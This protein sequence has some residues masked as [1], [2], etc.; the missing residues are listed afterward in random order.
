MVQQPLRLVESRSLDAHAVVAP[1]GLQLTLFTDPLCAETWIHWQ[2]WLALEE[3]LVGRVSCGIR[4]TLLLLAP[5]EQLADDARIHSSSAALSRAWHRARSAHL[6]EG[7]GA[8]LWL[9]DPPSSSVPAALAIKA[10]GLQ[11]ESAERRLFHALQDGLGHA[12]RN[13]SRSEQVAEIA[14][15][16]AR[17]D[18]LDLTQWRQDLVSLDVLE[19]L[20]QDLHLCRTHAIRHTPVLLLQG[21][22]PRAL[23]LPLHAPRLGTLIDELIELHEERRLSNLSALSHEPEEAA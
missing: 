19:R 4:M 2:R 23:Q 17:R 20:R 11:G 8:A 9:L 6:R 14:R 10:A 5:H 15:E 7:T 22:T 1:L 16:C 18:A 21:V 12:G 3:R 13:I